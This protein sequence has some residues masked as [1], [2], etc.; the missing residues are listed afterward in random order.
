MAY[1]MEAVAGGVDLVGVTCVGAGGDLSAA[2]VCRALD[3]GIDQSLLPA[4]WS[5]AIDAGSSGAE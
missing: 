4:G 1:G 3:P 2:A 5:Q